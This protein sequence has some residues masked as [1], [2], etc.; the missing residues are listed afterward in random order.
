MTNTFTSTASPTS[1]PWVVVPC[2]NEEKWIGATLDA[3]AAQTLDDFRLVLVD[4]G[5]TDGT[6]AVIEERLRSSRLRDVIVLDEPEKGTGRAADTGFRHAIDRGAEVVCRTDADCLPC[7]TW[8]AELC[9]AMADGGLD[10]AGGKL[11]VRTDDIGL[12][13]WRLIP[14]RIGI[15]LIGPLGRLLPSNRGKRF[16]SRY[17]LLPGPNVAIRAEAYLRCGR[18]PTTIIRPH[19]PR[20]G[21][22]QRFAAPNAEH[23]VCAACSRAL[24]RTPHGGLWCLGDHPVDTEPNWARGRDRRAMTKIAPLA[25]RDPCRWVANTRQV[26]TDF[27]N[28]AE[29]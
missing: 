27:A 28:P 15:R 25:L 7:P 4:N 3:L 18:L 11:L 29:P 2:Y 20:Q 10:A 26:D 14:S 21:D 12:S 17:V 19:S 1:R 6:R 13:W 22:R 23:R 9:K 16:L 8:L 5:S 24:L